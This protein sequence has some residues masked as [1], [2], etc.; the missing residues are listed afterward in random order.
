MLHVRHATPYASGLSLTGFWAGQTVGRAGL[1]W[2]TERFGERRCV[3]IYLVLAVALQLVFWLVPHFIVSAVSAGLLGMFLGP[4]FPS[5]IIMAA[6]LLPSHLHVSSL[7]FST[8]IG[9][10]GGA[11]APFIVGAIA[12]AKGLQVL[13]PIVI[14]LL[15]LLIIVWLCFPRVKER[16]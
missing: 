13:Q 7:G 9:G 2:V 8:A 1:G 11:I 16:T 14:A 4:M 5:C 10:T 15:G 6:K 12:E 3:S